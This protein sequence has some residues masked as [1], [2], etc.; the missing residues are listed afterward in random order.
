[1]SKV[2]NNRRAATSSVQVLTTNTVYVNAGEELRTA[3]VPFLSK[4]ELKALQQFKTPSGETEQNKFLVFYCT[5]E[6]NEGRVSLETDTPPPLVVEGICAAENLRENGFYIPCPVIEDPKWRKSL[7]NYKK[8]LISTSRYPVCNDG[9]KTVSR[10]SLVREVSDMDTIEMYY[11]AFFATMSK[12]IKSGDKKYAKNC[13][14]LSRVIDIV[15]RECCPI[16]SPSITALLEKTE[17]FKKLIL[18][19][20][21][22][23]DDAV[24]Y[25]KFV[26]D[27][28]PAHYYWMLYQLMLEC[29]EV[30][31][32]SYFNRFDFILGLST[33][34]TL[35]N[36]GCTYTG[37]DDSLLRM[38]LERLMKLIPKKNL[39]DFVDK[40][41]LVEYVHKISGKEF[42]NSLKYWALMISLIRNTLLDRTLSKNEFVARAEIVRSNF[43]D[44]KGITSFCLSICPGAVRYLNDEVLAEMIVSMSQ[45]DK[46]NTILTTAALMSSTHTPLLDKIIQTNAGRTAQL[47]SEL[48]TPVVEDVVDSWAS[49]LREVSHNQESANLIHSSGY[50]TH[51]RRII[52]Y[53]KRGDEFSLECLIQLLDEGYVVNPPLIGQKRARALVL[54]ATDIDSMVFNHFVGDINPKD[55]I[56][57]KTVLPRDYVG[58]MLRDISRDI[59]KVTF[60]D[61]IAKSDIPYEMTEYVKF[62]RARQMIMEI[63]RHITEEIS[64][65]LH[66]CYICFEERPKNMMV[67]L[68][69]DD[70]HEV[71]KGCRTQLNTCPFCRVDL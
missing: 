16:Q 8:W 65:M 27:S 60:D 59:S 63:E 56:R 21:A 26:S 31:H 66:E 54:R 28:N 57:M 70:R 14:M 53:A 5:L 10:N 2:V 44:L 62:E 11:A 39:T 69:N 41:E 33:Q 64:A 35:G 4:S 13:W 52:T 29:P 22:C 20:D 38:I 61:K 18:D 50:D 68:H 15:T 3:L 51:R 42:E 7:A 25:K 36:I 46:K 47:Q 24:A 43:A 40:G 37:I 67:T 34:K 12:F 58:T 48:A 49:L 45:A 6:Y 55:I 17:T 1:M 9:L 32:K 19:R 23:Y 30:M 71:C